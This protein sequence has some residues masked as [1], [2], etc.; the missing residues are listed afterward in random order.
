[1]H[2][3]CRRLPPAV[4]PRLDAPGTAAWSMTSS[5]MSDHNNS[6]PAGT[7]N[8]PYLSLPVPW[9]SRLR[10]SA[11]LDQRR[12]RAPDRWARLWPPR[13][14]YLPSIRTRQSSSDWP[15]SHIPPVFLL[16]LFY[17]AYMTPISPAPRPC[18]PHLPR[19]WP[20]LQI[21]L[22][23]KGTYGRMHPFFV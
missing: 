7:S 4:R 22:A 23:A 15:L 8:L 16:R 10:G 14:C 12:R 9:P 19:L 17:L 20:A 3:T 2:G 13:R 21:P 18:L 6:C 5:T 1:M 11:L